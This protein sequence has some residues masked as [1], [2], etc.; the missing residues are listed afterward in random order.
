MYVSCWD[1]TIKIF[2]LDGTEYIGQV[3]AGEGPEKMMRVG[4]TIWVL[5]QGGFSVDSTITV[6]STET[7]QVVKT[8]Q[9]YPKPT[10][11]QTDQYDHVWVLCSGKG[12]N[13]FPGPGDSEGHL[14]CFNPFDYSVIKDLDFPDASN[15]PEKL[16]IDGNGSNLFYNHP[17]GIFRFDV[18]AP[19]LEEEPFV[20]RQGMF[21]GLGMDPEGDILYASDPLDYVQKGRVYRY[22]AVTGALVDSLEAGVIPGEFYFGRFLVNTQ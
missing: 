12:W 18:L 17:D 5:N 19:V 14:V 7:D 1:N 10:G 21:Y 2:T 4:N 9:V 22:N 15:H 20:P 11:I 13:G 3:Q 6:I 16:V 8:L